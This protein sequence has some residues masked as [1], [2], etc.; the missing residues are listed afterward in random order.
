MNRVLISL[1]ILSSGVLMIIYTA[2][3]RANLRN[4]TVPPVSEWLCG[5]SLLLPLVVFLIVMVYYVYLIRDEWR[6]RENTI[7]RSSI[8]EGIDKLSSGLC[9]YVENKGNPRTWSSF[10]KTLTDYVEKG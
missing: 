2:E 4:L 10:V 6:F 5:Q 7:T 3:A 9:F 8:K 1:G